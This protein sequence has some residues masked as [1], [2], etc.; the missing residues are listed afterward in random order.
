MTDPLGHGIGP[1]I[2]YDLV[3]SWISKWCLVGQLE[4]EGAGSIERLPEKALLKNVLS[5]ATV[6]GF[7][8]CGP[9]EI[10]FERGRPALEFVE[11]AS[12]NE[13]ANI[14]PRV[15]SKVVV[16]DTELMPVDRGKGER[17][18]IA[19]ERERGGIRIIPP[20]GLEDPRL[21]FDI[22]R[23]GGHCDEA[24]EQVYLSDEN[25]RRWRT[26]C[27]C[28]RESSAMGVTTR[29]LLDKLHGLYIHTCQE[30]RPCAA[31]MHI[32]DRWLGATI[33]HLRIHSAS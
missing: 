29:V 9:G 24:R 7:D 23:M 33:S 18:I 25:E 12:G 13:V 10:G 5:C 3:V 21:G 22:Y 30:C 31:H 15:R 20:S 1:V 11:L 2:L 17:R 16:G 6:L 26:G 28:E 19:R 8:V 27:G 14:I 32:Q 4:V